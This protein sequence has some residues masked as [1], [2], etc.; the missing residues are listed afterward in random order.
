MR[1]NDESEVRRA[2]RKRVRGRVEWVML[3]GGRT[4]HSEIMWYYMAR[5]AHVPLQS[6]EAE[7]LINPRD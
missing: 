1:G 3:W 5:S 6:D 7:V 4:V 2:G